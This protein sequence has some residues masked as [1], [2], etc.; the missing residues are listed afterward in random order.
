MRNFS[1][2]KNCGY[3][4]VNQASSHISNINSHNNNINNAVYQSAGINP[5]KLINEDNKKSG[6]LNNTITAAGG[7]GTRAR[8]QRT[9]AS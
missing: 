6:I 1:S 5:D 8:K 4:N 9:S 7:G 3:S 2:F